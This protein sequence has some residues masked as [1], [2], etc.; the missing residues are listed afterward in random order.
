MQVLHL[1]WAYKQDGAGDK[2][3]GQVTALPFAVPSEP[4]EQPQ[5]LAGCWGYAVLEQSPSP[6]GTG[7]SQ[8]DAFPC[9]KELAHQ[10]PQFPSSIHGWAGLSLPLG[11][12]GGG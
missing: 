1:C 9:Q 5:P 7:C 3:T 10:L 12:E 8:R 4:S 6:A 2:A 11:G